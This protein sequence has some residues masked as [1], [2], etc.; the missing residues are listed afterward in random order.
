MLHLWIV[1]IYC[2]RYAFTQPM[3]ISSIV[4]FVAFEHFKRDERLIGSVLVRN[5]KSSRHSCALSCSKLST[6]RSFNFFDSIICE[7]N[8]EDVFSVKWNNSTPMVTFASGEYSAMLQNHVPKCQ[9]NGILVDIHNDVNPGKCYINNKRVDSQYGLWEMKKH[10]TDTDWKVYKERQL[11]LPSAHGGINSPD[12]TKKTLSWF[13]I[14]NHLNWHDG[15]NFCEALN[16]TMFSR[17]NSTVEQLDFFY[18]I[19]PQTSLWLGILRGEMNGGWMTADGNVLE[20]QQ[21]VWGQNYPYA[22]STRTHVTLGYGS[23]TE[24]KFYLRNN[25]PSAARKTLCDLV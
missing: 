5:R 22:D 21:L 24:T 19:F 23:K 14:S 12:G 17:V 15:W 2:L 11:L 13:K 9:Q 16:G 20:S 6:C 4:R 1:F 7:L 8:S 10:H 25:K 3:L 18:N